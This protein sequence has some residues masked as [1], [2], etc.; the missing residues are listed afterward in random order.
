MK[1]VS[2]FKISALMIAAMFAHQAV[3]SGYH[4]GTQSVGSQST[5]NSAAAEAADASTIFY[6]PAGLTKLD[7]RGEFTIA[8]NMVMPSIKYSNAKAQYMDGT[9]VTQG[10]DHGKITELTFAPHAYGAYK[11]NDRVTL[12]V[13]MYIPFGSKTEYEQD[14]VLR[15]NMNKLG[16]TTVAFEPVVAF[17][18]N[19][20]HS[21]GVGL[22]G[23]YSQAELRKFAD[24]N[25]SGRLGVSKGITDGHADVKGHDWGFGYHLGWLFDVND[26]VR[27]GVNY[28]SKVEHNLK[29]TAHWQADGALAKAYYAAAIGKP[30]SAGGFGYVPTENASVKI[31]T[32][33]SLSVHGMYR[34]NDKLDLYGDVTWTRHSRFNTAELIF[35]NTK[36][37]ARGGLANSTTIRPNW[38]NT[39][40]VAVGGSY[41]YSQ[42]LQL[43]AGIAFDQT[44]VKSS[45][46]RL[47]TL[48]DGNRL[49]LSAGARYTHKQRHVFDIAYSYIHIN[50]TEYRAEAATGNDIDSRGA[51]SASFKNYAAILGAQYTYK[52]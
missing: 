43:R 49:W 48:P 35:E 2:P 23:Q 24:W 40:K 47:N 29:G 4:F 41:Q 46:D 6:N 21:F 16:L 5:A 51:T 39:F 3:A 30:V 15:Y 17:K 13:G 34:A 45:A 32:P 18:A 12:G 22:I 37:V 25:A 38:R 27:V 42:P 1:T 9:S 36:R 19:E 10:S 8:A 33:E 44:P 52:F 31:I 28:R 14:S 7:G 50:D 11:L 26:R 20:K